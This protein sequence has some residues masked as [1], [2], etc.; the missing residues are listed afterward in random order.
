MVRKLTVRELPRTDDARAL[1][2]GP[3][4]RWT[5]DGLP[6]GER[7]DITECNGTWRILRVRG[8]VLE[9]DAREFPTAE[10]AFAA[11]VDE[12]AEKRG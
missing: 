11:L 7:A 6:E 4:R 9:N 8:G 1:G 5:V 2:P 12:H 10:T 3:V